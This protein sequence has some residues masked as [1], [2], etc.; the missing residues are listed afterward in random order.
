MDK[1]NGKMSGL[2][3]NPRLYSTVHVCL[4]DT[5]SDEVAE[6]LY[7]EA[8]EYKA[9]INNAIRDFHTHDYP[10]NDLMRYFSLPS[11]KTMEASIREKV[12]SAK[13]AVCSVRNTLYAV[14]NLSMSA[15]LTEEEVDAFQEQVESQYR[16]GWGAEFELQDIKTSGHDAICVRLCYDGVAFYTADE[17]DALIAQQEPGHKM[18]ALKQESQSESA[19]PSLRM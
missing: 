10:T 3:D 15:D 9:D 8:A 12:Q 18:Q 14:L 11:E 13:L 7:G 4:L 16:D 1:Y 2:I 17:F 6:A 19:S 5:E